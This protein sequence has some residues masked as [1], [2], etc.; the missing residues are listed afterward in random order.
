MAPFFDGPRLTLARHLA[1][2]R[3]NELA[4]R[5][6]K[7]PSAITA[8]EAGAKHPTA[9]NIAQ[10]ALGLEVDPWFFAV[11]GQDLTSLSTMP[12]FRSLRST[13][14]QARDQ[15]YAYGKLAVDVASALEVH[16]EFPAMDLPTFPVTPEDEDH[17][18]VAARAVRAAWSLGTRPL[19]H[20]VRM[21]EHRGVLVV[22]SP[23]QTASVDAYSFGTPRRQVVVLN[24]IKRDFYRQRFDLAHELGHL[25]MH[26]DAEPGGR[27]VENQA[28]M[29][30]SEFL[31]P[32]EEVR[33]ML[34]T[35]MGRSSWTTLFRL[36]EHWGVSVAALLFRARR[37]GRLSDVSYR[38][39]MV[40][41]TKKGW[42]RHEPGAVA[43]IEQPSLLPRAV[44][45]LNGIGIS[46]GELVTQCR[47]PLHLFR[48]VTSRTP[49]EFTDQPQ[50]SHA[51]RAPE[52]SGLPSRGRGVVSLLQPS[53]DFS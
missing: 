47:V 25:V 5:I 51:A 34:P 30:A 10:L 22:F 53:A 26:N 14:Q 50:G 41:M 52:H 35:T 33:D 27:V 9:A 38:N 2:L 24:P 19:G 15:A 42:R 21:L 45:L 17:P 44:E 3:K 20:C 7:S 23:R 48:A 32:A 11:R 18:E 46:E 40:A 28:H 37:L 29:F 36:K 43:S 39:A 1:G 12:H 13:T 49:M 8:W 31:M 4:S 16:A 6:D